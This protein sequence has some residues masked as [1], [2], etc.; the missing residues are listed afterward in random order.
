MCKYFFLS[1]P[2]LLL[3]TIA[4]ATDWR[5]LVKDNSIFLD[6]DSVVFLKNPLRV[7]FDTKVIQ[8]D[9][10]HYIIMNWGIKCHSGKQYLN[11]ASIYNLSNDDYI[12]EFK[13]FEL[14]KDEDVQAGVFYALYSGFCEK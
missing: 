5:P 8:A 11:R 13:G 7:T 12:R 2:L 6:K 4:F 14:N 3:S 10:G 9:K 1:L